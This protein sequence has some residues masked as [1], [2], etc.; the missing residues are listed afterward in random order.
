MRV[1]VLYI[2]HHVQSCG[3]RFLG[4]LNV[5]KYVLLS[6]HSMSKLKAATPWDSTYGQCLFFQLAVSPP[7]YML[8][9]Y[10]R[11][12]HVYVYTVLCSPRSGRQRTALARVMVVLRLVSCLY[13]HIY[14][15]IYIYTVK[16]AG[17]GI[18]KL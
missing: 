5:N 8:H 7:S 1:R 18:G 16:Q 14:T 11:G 2:Y 3:V 15:Y 6:S 17:S 10:A 4:S 12:I 13:C 9:V